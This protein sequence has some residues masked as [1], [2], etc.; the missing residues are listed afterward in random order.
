MPGLRHPRLA[1]AHQGRDASEQLRLHAALA[2]P[3]KGDRHRQ[4]PPGEL[5]GAAGPQAQV[6][7]PIFAPERRAS[8][9]ERG[10]RDRV[11]AALAEA[12][13]QDRRSH[14]RQRVAACRQHPVDQHAALLI[15]DHVQ[16]VH[17]VVTDGAAVRQVRDPLKRRLASHRAYRGRRADFALETLPL[18]RQL[19]RPVTMHGCVHGGK[20][21]SR[22]DYPPR[23]RTDF[24]A[25]RPACTQSGEYDAGPPVNRD[26]LA[27]ARRR[28]ACALERARDV[29]L[30]GRERY[31]LL[32][33]QLE[34]AA[35]V[36][37]EHLAL[38]PGADLPHGPLRAAASSPAFGRIM[39]LSSKIPPRLFCARLMTNSRKASA[40]ASAPETP[41]SCS[42]S[43]RLPSR[44]PIPDS[45]MGKDMIACSTTRIQPMVRNDRSTSRARATSQKLKMPIA[46]RTTANSVI[47]SAEAWNRR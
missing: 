25:Q 36:L 37:H 42:N 21:T 10:M 6:A 1:A 14:V 24:A 38:V 20:L 33:E 23:T 16:H 29:D 17:V 19:A 7:A 26:E 39:F 11:A 9:L 12:Q 18:G 30:G 41:Y 31:E 27:D 5:A 32:D 3:R 47:M 13:L 15:H 28:D 35:V 22:T 8:Q 2:T 45:E 46:W 40:T 44:T 34:D 43:T 4:L